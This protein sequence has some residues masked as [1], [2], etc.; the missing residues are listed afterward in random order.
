MNA[1]A[2]QNARLVIKSMR[3]NKRLSNRTVK[4]KR[5]GVTGVASQNPHR[6][7]FNGLGVYS[8][9]SQTQQLC[10][11]LYLAPSWYLQHQYRQQH[12]R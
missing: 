5:G 6:H 8:R 3:I 2:I 1:C 7:P 10:L 4:K 11:Y 12:R 9:F